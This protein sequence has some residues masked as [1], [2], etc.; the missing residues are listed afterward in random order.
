MRVRDLIRR[1]RGDQNRAQG[2]IDGQAA[3]IRDLE[4]RLTSSETTVLKLM[5]GRGGVDQ[6]GYLEKELNRR[7]RIIDQL[8]AGVVDDA[9]TAELRRQLRQAK[10]IASALTLR[11][12][13]L[14][15]AN[16]GIPRRV[17]V[18]S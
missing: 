6:V 14:Q 3:K 18:A 2:V 13:N 11:I 12:E 8:R 9:Q 4:S 17:E 15:A 7:A 1:F 5:A 16:S 10:G